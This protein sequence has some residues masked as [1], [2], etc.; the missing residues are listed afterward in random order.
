MQKEEW[1]EDEAK[2][3]LLQ[4]CLITWSSWQAIQ[5]SV[6]R[7]FVWD[8]HFLLQDVLIGK[9]RTI[10]LPGYGGNGMLIWRLPSTS[11]ANLSPRLST[12]D[13]IYF[14]ESWLLLGEGVKI[15]SSKLLWDFCKHQS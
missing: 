2:R 8:C 11:G 14:N 10:K 5:P 12:S 7:G 9:Q 6:M 4:G 3:N 13:F 1:K 15:T